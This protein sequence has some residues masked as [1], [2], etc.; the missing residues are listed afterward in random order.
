MDFSVTPRRRLRLEGGSEPRPASGPAPGP[1]PNAPRALGPPQPGPFPPAEVAPSRVTA[2]AVT[3]DI[4]R[5]AGPPA[6]HPGT[7]DLPASRSASSGKL[8]ARLGL[9]NTRELFRGKTTK[10]PS[11]RR[12]RRSPGAGDRNAPALPGCRR[13]PGSPL[14]T[15][16]CNGADPQD[17]RH[18]VGGRPRP[19]HGHGAGDGWHPGRGGHLGSGS[20][21]GAGVGVDVVVGQSRLWG[22][23]VLLVGLVVTLLRQV[24]DL[25]P[26]DA[27][28]GADR[29]HI[30]LVAHAIGQQAIPDLPGEDARIPLFVGPDMFYHRGG[31]DPRL[32]ASDSPREDGAGLVVASQDFADTAVGNAELPAD[33]ARPDT[34]LRQFHNPQPDGIGQG[35]PVDKHPPE[36]VHFPEGRFCKQTHKHTRRTRRMAQKGASELL[37]VTRQMSQL[38]DPPATHSTHASLE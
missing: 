1:R 13:G 18:R 20:G 25:V 3:A 12:G 34:Q 35:S 16:V 17:V 4:V 7:S 32:A 31:G 14:L 5:F 2:A 6:A 36:L 33:V 29:R 10:P 9:G 30:V 26:E 15:L 37:L 22:R 28:D 19:G 27:A 38:G 24:P 11:D 23:L 8:G 21:D